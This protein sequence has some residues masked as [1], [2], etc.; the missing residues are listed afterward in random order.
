MDVFDSVM[1]HHNRTCTY[2]GSMTDVSSFPASCSTLCDTYSQLRR[3]LKC[4]QDKIPVYITG[5]NTDGEFTDPDHRHAQSMQDSTRDLLKAVKDSSP[6]RIVW[7]EKD[8]LVVLEVLDRVTKST[9]SLLW[10][11]QNKSSLILPRQRNLWV[12]DTVEWCRETR[13]ACP[14]PDG[15]GF[16]SFP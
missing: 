7:S 2:R 8:A 15:E 14:L 1:R 12:T 3:D 10:G 6:I 16:G 13:P 11:V 5:T 4:G 9:G